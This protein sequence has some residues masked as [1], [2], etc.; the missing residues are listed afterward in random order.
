MLGLQ[1]SIEDRLN[2]SPLIHKKSFNNLFQDTMNLFDDDIGI[3]TSGESSNKVETKVMEPNSLQKKT[4]MASV[5]EI[6]NSQRKEY[7]SLIKENKDLSED[8]TKD[9][10]ESSSEEETNI[11]W[12]D[13]KFR[14]YN[15]KINE[16]FINIDFGE[17]FKDISKMYII[18]N[19]GFGQYFDIHHVKDNKQSIKWDN[20]GLTNPE[21]KNLD[22]YSIFLLEKG[23]KDMHQIF[24]NNNKTVLNCFKDNIGKD[25]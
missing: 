2:T 21:H 15:D 6:I 9:E 7:D 16:R 24:L 10:T 23:K 4:S 8:K 11:N 13:I 25:W 19:D 17:Q 1:T 14:I 5:F 22:V 20:R 18:T 3:D 12:E